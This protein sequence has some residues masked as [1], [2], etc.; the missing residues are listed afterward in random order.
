VTSNNGVIMALGKTWKFGLLFRS[1]E[2]VETNTLKGKMLET[3]IGNRLSAWTFE[4]RCLDIRQVLEIFWYLN[5]PGCFWGLIEP[6]FSGQKRLLPW[7]QNDSVS[8][9]YY[10]PYIAEL[11]YSHMSAWRIE[12]FARS[13]FGLVSY[14]NMNADSSSNSKL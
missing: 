1:C 11:K 9:W 3:G 5:K 10:L 12:T 7:G 13:I 4:H 14:R 8:S 2:H 6:L